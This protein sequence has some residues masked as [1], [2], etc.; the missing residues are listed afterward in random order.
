M[1]LGASRPNQCASRQTRLSHIKRSWREVNFG[2]M[3]NSYAEIPRIFFE[4]EC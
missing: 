1:D 2:H 3:L 4:S